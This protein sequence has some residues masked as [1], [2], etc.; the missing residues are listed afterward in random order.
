MGDAQLSSGFQYQTARHRQT[1]VPRPKWRP[2][3]WGCWMR[4]GEKMLAE[5]PWTPAG[6]DGWNIFHI[7][8]R[9]FQVVSWNIEHNWTKLDEGFSRPCWI[10]K[11]LPV[12]FFL[13]LTLHSHLACTLWW[14]PRHD[15][16][17]SL[18]QS[19]RCRQLFA[20]SN[21]YSCC[22]HLCFNGVQGKIYKKTIENHWFSHE[23]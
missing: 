11:R 15:R 8:S 21:S 4:R 2:C 23:I 13:T 14:P 16:I 6:D 20:W 17:K 3:C 19:P 9:I 10:T 18:A 7:T 22:L 12:Q 5:N 1:F